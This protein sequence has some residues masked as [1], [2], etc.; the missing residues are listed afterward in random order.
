M[1]EKKYGGF[2]TVSRYTPKTVEHNKFSAAVPAV[3]TFDHGF[4]K[5]KK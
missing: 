4:R 1:C 5:I 2:E 3:W